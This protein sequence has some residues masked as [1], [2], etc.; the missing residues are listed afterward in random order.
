[1]AILMDRDRYPATGAPTVN[2]G[3][4]KNTRRTIYL[5]SVFQ[6]DSASLP[7]LGPDLVYRDPW[8]NPYIITFDLN[9]DEDCRDVF[10]ARSTVSK[11]TSGYDN[12]LTSADPSGATDDFQYRGKVMIWSLGPDKKADEKQKANTPPN[13]DNILSWK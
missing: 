11:D 13:R 2:F 12:G 1:M 4:V 10:Y 8:G 7:G 3:H 6:A 9:F 5:N